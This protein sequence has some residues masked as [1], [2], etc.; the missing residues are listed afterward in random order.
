MLSVYYDRRINMLPPS[1]EK[2]PRAEELIK[3]TEKPQIFY[4]LEGEKEFTQEQ[5]KLISEAINTHIH[6]NPST[7]HQV[8]ITILDENANKFSIKFEDNSKFYISISK[9]K[10]DDAVVIQDVVHSNFGYSIKKF[11]QS[12]INLFYKPDTSKR[13]GHKKAIAQDY[14]SLRKGLESGR[15]WYRGNKHNKIRVRSET[16]DGSKIERKQLEREMNSAVKNA[17]KM[18]SALGGRDQAHHLNILARKFS[19]DIKQMKVDESIIIPIGY[20]NRDGI[21]QPVMLRFMMDKNAKL[22]LDIY[23]DAAEGKG[24]ISPLHKRTFNEGT[25]EKEIENLLSA[26]FKPLIS[27]RSKKSALRSA[28]TPGKTFSHLLENKMEENLGKHGVESSDESSKQTAETSVSSVSLSFIGL[29]ESL[30][31]VML[32]KWSDSTDKYQNL[33]G[34]PT[35]PA[36]RV[37]DWFNEMTGDNKNKLTKNEKLNL[38]YFMTED[39]LKGQET[40]LTRKKRSPEM[41]LEVYKSCLGQIQHMKEKIACHINGGNP[42]E[43]EHIPES[44]KRRESKYQAKIEKLEKIV[45]K[46]NLE[47]EGKTLSTPQSEELAIPFTKLA[48]IPEIGATPVPIPVEGA[49]PFNQV[50][51]QAGW[52]KAKEKLTAQLGPESLHKQQEQQIKL[53]LGHVIEQT[54]A[55]YRARLEK[56]SSPEEILEIQETLK[57]LKDFSIK[58]LFGEGGQLDTDKLDELIS[59]VLINTQHLAKINHAEHSTID[60]E[61]LSSVIRQ[62]ILFPHLTPSYK[63]ERNDLN[64]FSAFIRAVQEPH[65][66]VDPELQTSHQAIRALL[67]LRHIIPA[68]SLQTAFASRWDPQSDLLFQSKKEDLSS[69]WET[70]LQTLTTFLESNQDPSDSETIKKMAVGELKYEIYEITLAD[71]L[72]EEKAA[73]LNEIRENYENKRAEKIENKDDQGVAI[74]DEVIDWLV[75]EV[76]NPVREIV[77]FEAG[78]TNSDVQEPF[79]VIFEPSSLAIDLSESESN[80]IDDTLSFAKTF[81]KNLTDLTTELKTLRQAAISEQD[82]LRKQS[83]IQES[84]EKALQILSLLPPPGTEGTLGTRCIWNDFSHEQR[85]TILD[86]VH[87]LEHLVWEAQ[88]KLAQSKI[89]GKDRFLMIKAQTIRLAIIRAEV[90]HKKN[91]TEIL[92]TRIHLLDPDKLKKFIDKKTLFIDQDT[93]EIRIDLKSFPNHIESVSK[94]IQQT[95]DTYEKVTNGTSSSAEERTFVEN[96][97]TQ[98]L[99]KGNVEAFT[100]TNDTI[101]WDPEAETLTILWENGEQ[102]GI[103]PTI[104]WEEIQN[105]ISSENIFIDK[106]NIPE[107]EYFYLDEGTL[108]TELI[109]QLLSQDL[110]ACLSGNAEMERDL[111]SVY[112]FVVRDQNRAELRR[113]GFNDHINTTQALDN[114]AG[115]KP[116]LLDPEKQMSDVLGFAVVKQFENPIPL[117]SRTEK[118][119]LLTK[120]LSEIE[121]GEYYYRTASDPDFTLHPENPIVGVSLFQRD[122]ALLMNQQKLDI[123]IDPEKP[124]R[125]VIRGDEEQTVSTVYTFGHPDVCYFTREQAS[126][127]EED[128]EYRIRASKPFLPT[129]NQSIGLAGDKLSDI[130][131]LKRFDV[132]VQYVSERTKGES[133]AIPPQVL[134]QLFQIRQ[135]PS[136]KKNLRTT[137]HYQSDTA[138]RALSFIANPENQPYLTHDFVQQFL[139]ESLFGSML[140]Q[141]ALS[142]HPELVINNMKLLDACLERAQESND[143][144]LIG[145]LSHIVG[146]IQSHVAYTTEQLS[147]NGL[148]SGLVNGSLPI[149]LGKPGGLFEYANAETGKA[150]MHEDILGFGTKGAATADFAKTVQPLSYRLQQLRLCKEFIDA[151][152]EK[153]QSEDLSPHHLL[154][155]EIDGERKIDAYKNPRERKQAYSVIIESFKSKQQREGS[156]PLSEIDLKEILIGYQL[157]T[158]EGIEGGVPSINQNLIEWVRDSVL[159]NISKLNDDKRSTILTTVVNAQLKNQNLKDIDSGSWVQDALSPNLFILELPDKT[160]TFDLYSM[161]IS[162]LSLTKVANKPSPIP[163]SILKRDDVQQAFH[164]SKIMA[165]RSVQSGVESYTWKKE[166]QTFEIRIAGKQVTIKRTIESDDELNGEYIFQPVQIES[167]DNHAHSLLKENGLWLREDSP[168]IGYLFEN[169]TQRPSVEKTYFATIEH[170]QINSI[171]DSDGNFVSQSATFESTSPLLFAKAENVVTLLDRESKLPNKMQIKQIDLTLSKGGNGWECVHGVLH[172]PD[173]QE[174]KQLIETFGENWDQYIIPLQK[175]GKPVYLMIPYAQTVDRKG[176]VSANQ[177]SIAQ[178]TAPEILQPDENGK[179]RG[180]ITSDLYLAHKL[181]TQGEN[182]KNPTQARHLFQQ[183]E[184]HLQRLTAERP[185]SSPDEIESLKRVLQLITQNPS[186]HLKETPSPIALS[187]SLKLSLKVRQFRQ[188]SKAQGVT[189]LELSAAEDL[190]ELETITKRFEAYSVMEKS[191]TYSMFSNEAQ[192]HKSLFILEDEEKVELLNISSQLLQNIYKSTTHDTTRSY[193]GQTGGLQSTIEITPA[194]KLNPQFIQALIRMGKPYNEN[195]V[196]LSE[197][198]N[199][200]PLG[201]LIENFWSYFIDINEN[202]ITPDQLKF[203]FDPSIIPSGK[204]PEEEQQLIDLDQQA[205]QFLL[206]M[207]HL[208][209]KMGPDFNPFQLASEGIDEAKDEFKNFAE[210]EMSSFLEQFKAKPDVA[211]HLNDLLEN[212]ETFSVHPDEDDDKMPDVD[213]LE[214]EVTEIETKINLFADA[215]ESCVSDADTLINKTTKEKKK[216]EDTFI[217]LNNEYKIIVKM[218]EEE[219]DALYESYSDREI[220]EQVKEEIQKQI[221]PS[222]LS[223]YEQLGVKIETAEEAL[224]T[225]LEKTVKD[226]LTGEDFPQSSIANGNYAYAIKL[227]D[228]RSAHSEVVKKQTALNTTIKQLKDNKQQLEQV[229]KLETVVKSIQTTDFSTDSWFK[230]PDEGSAAT[231]ISGILDST[232]DASEYST[233]ELLGV[234]SS[235]VKRVGVGSSIKLGKFFSQ[236]Q[237]LLNE[238]D[239]IQLRAD[240]LAGE[241]S[242]DIEQKIKQLKKAIRIIDAQLVL[243]PGDHELTLKKTELETKKTNF[244]ALKAENETLN[245]RINPTILGRLQLFAVPLV[246]LTLAIDSPIQVTPSVTPKAELDLQA[247]DEKLAQQC[248]TEKQITD[249]K[250]RLESMEPKDRQGYIAN[251]NTALKTNETLLSAQIGLGANLRR[252]KDTFEEKVKAE[253]TV[254]A[255]TE[256][257]SI[258]TVALK[259]G[260]DGAGYEKFYAGKLDFTTDFTQLEIAIQDEGIENFLKKFM[261]INSPEG[262]IE[263]KEKFPSPLLTP[264]IE[265]LE[266]ILDPRI[267][268]E[269]KNTFKDTLRTATTVEEALTFIQAFYDEISPTFAEKE[270]ETLIT[271]LKTTVPETDS[272]YSRGL[273]TGIDNVNKN[274]PLSYSTLISSEKINAVTDQITSDS[275]HLLTA[276]EESNKAIVSEIK[277]MRLDDLPKSLQ[278][279]RIRKGSDNELLATI[280]NEYSK[281]EFADKE[282]DQMIGTSLINQTRVKAL[283]AALSSIKKLETLND[284]RFGIS[285]TAKLKAIELEWRRE[286]NKIRD[287][288]I[289]CQ[290]TEHLENLPTELQPHARSLIYLQFRTGLVLRSNQIDTLQEIIEKPSLLKQLRMGLGKTSIILP[291]ALQIMAKEGFIP[292]GMVPK[293]LFSTNFKEMDETTRLAFELSGDQFLFNR[294]DAPQP[295]TDLSLHQLSQKC[296]AFFKAISNGQYILTTIESKAS[297][298][299]KISEVE[300]SQARIQSQIDR[301]NEDTE[302]RDDEKEEQIKAF[303]PELNNHQKAL[304][305]LYRVKVTFELPNTR[306][307]IDEADQVARAN[308]AVNSEMGDKVPIAP[309]LQSTVSTIFNLIRDSETCAVLREQIASNNQFTLNEKQKDEIIQSIAKE[310]LAGRM[311]SLP[312]E[313]QTDEFLNQLYPWFSGGDSP[314][315]QHDINIIGPFA[316]ELTAMR[317]ALNSSLRASLG[318]KIGLDGDFDPTHFAIGVPSSQGITSASTKY[319]DPLMQ[320]CLTQMIALYKPQGEAFLKSSIADVRGAISDQ[321]D[322]AEKENSESTQIPNLKAALEKI[323]QL[324]VRQKEGDATL[325]YREKFSGSDPINSLI[326]QK[327]SEQVGLRALIYVSENQISR[328]VQHALRGCNVI[329]LTGTATLN[330]EYVVTS[331][332]HTEGMKS[333]EEDGRVTTAE[334]LYRFAKSLPEGLETPIGT[335]P[336]DSDKAM[337]KFKY[338]ANTENGYNFLINQAGSCDQM[339]LRAIVEMLSS[340]GGRPIVFLDTDNEGRSEKKVYVDGKYD[341]LSQYSDTEKKELYKT[342]FFYYHTPHVRGTHF[343]I[344]TGSKGALLLSPTVNAND[345]DQAAYRARELGE[346]HIVEPFISD[347]QHTELGSGNEVTVREAFTV[348]HIQTKEDES[349]EDLSAYQLHLKGQAVRAAE[350]AKASLQLQGPSEVLLEDVAAQTALF[351]ILEKFFIDDSGNSSY[352]RLL[353]REALQG[354][355]TATNKYLETVAIKSEINRI[356]RVITAINGVSTENAKL[357]EA[358]VNLKEEMILAKES[359]ETESKGLDAKWDKKLSLQFPSKTAAASSVQETA[360]TEAEAEAEEQQE[361]TSETAAELERKKRNKTTK[362][363]LTELDDELLAQQVQVSTQKDRYLTIDGLKIYAACPPGEH[364]KEFPATTLWDPRIMVTNTLAYHIKNAVGGTVPE[365]KLIVI[366]IDGQKRILATTPDEGDHIV[367][368]DRHFAGEEEAVGGKIF[369]PD[370][371]LL[372]GCAVKPTFDTNGSLQLTFEA[373]GSLNTSYRDKFKEDENLQAEMYLTLIT[374]GHTQ[375]G[376][377][378]WEIISDYWEKLDDP[379]KAELKE[380]IEAKMEHSPFLDKLSKHLWNVPKSAKISLSGEVIEEVEVPEVT[381]LQAAK[382]TMTSYFSSP[383]K[384]IFSAHRAYI[385]FKKCFENENIAKNLQEELITWGEDQKSFFN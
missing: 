126:Y 263:F 366:D 51:W 23:T 209:Q 198:T 5:E 298:D 109:N 233:R 158:D 193:F 88:M 116:L 101:Q 145:Y 367:G 169:E 133:L 337:E 256:P 236:L 275:T 6:Y 179:I 250:E 328:P 57:D 248:F 303:I 220:T 105:K 12:I 346:G 11:F 280:F 325:N 378:G 80:P 338:F 322:L 129:V 18:E 336:L 207:A 127:T 149:H 86:D 326:R 13:R 89:P 219:F 56:A 364:Q 380:K 342:A 302:L 10:P 211:L 74:Y 226:P 327:F 229:R 138:I 135:S 375:I 163:D 55:I 45:R 24:K 150:S 100:T 258:E 306:I 385:E 216:L 360:E 332:G 343:T 329:G 197:R 294:Q 19:K 141:Q 81:T 44:L 165:L 218:I 167:P 357:E 97:Y 265:A 301:I 238:Q 53:E 251:L 26:A 22:S 15:Q 182:T 121:Q 271:S 266:M 62:M 122:P 324:L 350:K 37:V 221:T 171:T 358:L 319:S 184:M 14:K 178:L 60:E 49:L 259:S 87:T 1:P 148:L 41:Q 95:F 176:K 372:N 199:P 191:Q 281:G 132:W 134:Q 213:R 344:P 351:T 73:N 43:T 339:P 58:G 159:P 368:P 66:S 345:R 164:A 223:E 4:E 85:V 268:N 384:K 320:L 249:L 371:T 118:G 33:R 321:I 352:L 36:A 46:R 185:P 304:D 98:M 225:F 94:V 160:I 82:P 377:D 40:R 153:F 124:D 61:S 38:L 161:N 195:I 72:F 359:L 142:E 157:L 67:N 241:K 34:Q 140:F 245:L 52:Q 79:M 206:G 173:D 260:A 188:M 289:R 208:N 168:R 361:T 84:R 192:L 137:T 373:S 28:A 383:D 131:D 235:L 69:R 293:A 113:S 283:G 21:M 177:F 272:L 136:T 242:V 7:D 65:A 254:P 146:N 354:G 227:K 64:D 166:G 204:S 286:S 297:L 174:I 99:K 112:H 114:G 175:N 340:E 317:K 334:V 3:A 356:D 276:V 284:Q 128:K 115:R 170:D 264:Y 374:L 231:L 68:V 308:Y 252:I 363:V 130:R 215:L 156:Q 341:P 91:E 291:F 152:A 292:I 307:I 183:A 189:S 331:N 2:D 243:K 48:T 154:L 376:N 247:F 279:I 240:E 123:F 63:Q 285:D 246:G 214:G 323:D 330:T 312:E 70:E 282:V 77:F 104:E 25:D 210:S 365:M 309:L 217:Q 8:R 278:K 147:K 288:T 42:V 379:G 151:F 287:F 29:L 224:T 20:L 16:K 382:D 9:E 318:H 30:D 267:N 313:F 203:L 108:D 315:T 83:L 349:K 300:R 237:P 110:T 314:L 273:N 353:A 172:A 228:L 186:I 17:R 155:D 311:D 59:T 76:E 269:A 96:D 39:W 32:G 370:T 194:T 295:F 261:D 50:Q 107:L 257:P 71:S 381:D 333:V 316:N 348:H 27:E 117:V 187:L 35:T 90:A 119:A 78:M 202:N 93:N 239:N 139:E 262:L 190:K 335:Y 253:R 362:A 255:D 347:K 102:E 277:G 299:D 196:S 75:K 120:L 92:L 234:A 222:L 290:S 355:E 31:T 103:N 270:H 232:I 212:M 143:V 111:L 274:N 47:A 310:W 305:M 244:E 125:V 181:I 201:D 162:G 200:I 54:S 106:K 296:A 369:R 144:E 205:R 230:L 180:S